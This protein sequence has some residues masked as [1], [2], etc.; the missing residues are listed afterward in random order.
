MLRAVAPDDLVGLGERRDLV[1]PGAQGG[2]GACRAARGR[3]VGGLG[4]DRELGDRHRSSLSVGS[5]P[6]GR[7]GSYFKDAPDLRHPFGAIS[8]VKNVRSFDILKPMK[9]GTPDLATLGHRIRHFR[10]ERGLTLDQLGD[11]VGLAGSQLSLIEN[12]KREP[13]LST[14]D[15]LAGGARRRARRPARPRGAEPPGRARARAR[16]RAGEPALR[17]PSGLPRSA[18]AAASPTRRSRRSSGCTASCSAARA[19]PSRP[20][21]R[22]AARTPSCASACATATTTCPTSSSSPRSRCAPR[23]TARAR[24]RT[25]R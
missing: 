8:G 15:A 12:G 9:A 16:P 24:S 10:G 3:R 6:C 7:S 20:P 5:R 11:A 14:L 1:D 22:P 23:A 25:A 13:K 17:E 21:R 4:A 18:R 19:R 2:V